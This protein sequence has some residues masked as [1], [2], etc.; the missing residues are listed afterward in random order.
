MMK[1]CA[2]GSCVAALQRSTVCHL[3]ELDLLGTASKAGVLWRGT[4]NQ[5]QRF[6]QNRFVASSP[7]TLLDVLSILRTLSAVLT[8]IAACMVASNWSP[9]T[10]VAGFSVFVAASIAWIID[11]WLESKPSLIIQNAA[12]LGVNIFGIWRWLP[13]A[14][15]DGSA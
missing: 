3:A 1:F 5:T 6:Q 12:L 2:Q 4:K 9:K 8:V 13:K 10:M 11:G 7:G 14:S 15:N